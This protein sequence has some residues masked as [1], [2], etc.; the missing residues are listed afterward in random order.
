[1]VNMLNINLYVTVSIFILISTKSFSF[2]M[3]SMMKKLISE[4]LKK[5]KF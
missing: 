4:M 5:F 3:L 1:M 2:E